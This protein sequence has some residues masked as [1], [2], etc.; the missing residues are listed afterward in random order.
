MR[1]HC[2]EAQISGM[3]ENAQTF[4]S[5]GQKL[6]SDNFALLFQDYKEK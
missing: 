5:S 1:Q 2:K 6:Y 4:S 3:M